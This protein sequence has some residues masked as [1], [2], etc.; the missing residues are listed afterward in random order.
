[1][2]NTGA[3][4]FLYYCLRMSC[5]ILY[6]TTVK[7]SNTY[8][9]VYKHIIIVS[10]RRHHRIVPNPICRRRRRRGF[11]AVRTVIIWESRVE[12][13][14]PTTARLSVGLPQNT[15]LLYT[16]IYII[17]V[18]IHPCDTEHIIIII[19]IGIYA[20]VLSTKY[21]VIIRVLFI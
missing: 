4:R 16:F 9:T 17:Y 12:N 14:T 19:L 21:R 1:M 10:E 6:T 7:R 18:H 13:K 20:P 15:R 8:K 3:S 11:R 2:S 5:I